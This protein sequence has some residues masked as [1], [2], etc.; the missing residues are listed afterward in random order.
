M[1]VTMPCLDAM[2]DEWVRVAKPYP[3]LARERRKKFWRAVQKR[4]I[5]D[6]L[7]LAHQSAACSTLCERR[8]AARFS[9]RRSGLVGP[10]LPSSAS[11]CLRATDYRGV[12]RPRGV[13]AVICRLT[14]T[15]CPFRRV[16]VI[17]SRRAALLHIARAHSLPAPLRTPAVKGCFFGVH[18]FRGSSLL[19][20]GRS[21]RKPWRP[22]GHRTRPC[23]RLEL[24]SVSLVCDVV[25]S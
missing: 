5:D 20:Q 11:A 6:F 9:C 19:A 21:C 25:E 14:L 10:S 13:R 8:C 1:Y 22:R 23:C 4:R 3:S 2:N 17:P 15:R 24:G 7:Q 16:S 18:A 12:P